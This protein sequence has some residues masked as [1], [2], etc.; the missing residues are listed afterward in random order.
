MIPLKSSHFYHIYNR[1]NGSEK[2]FV[3]QENYRFFLEKFKFYISPFADTYAY[4]LMPNH[5]HFLIQV[6]EEEEIL[7][8]LQNLQGF[9]RPASKKNL[10]GL[11]R[12]GTEKILSN[13][14]SKFLNSYVKSFNKQQKRMGSLFMK[15]FKRKEITETAYLRNLIRYI[16]QNPVEARLCRSAEKWKFSSFNSILNM[17]S[18]FVKS[19]EVIEWFNDLDNLKSNHSYQSV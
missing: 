15:N 11:S 8:A 13:Q 14:F 1:A 5:F 7:L 19:S 6:K 17:D 12:G 3:S 2:I 4:C 18:D 16:H 9:A 10:E